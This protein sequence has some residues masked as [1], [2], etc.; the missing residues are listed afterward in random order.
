MTGAG[1]LRAREPDASGDCART[2]ATPR[3][4]P[5]ITSTGFRR[6]IVWPSM[7]RERTNFT[8]LP[9]FRPSTACAQGAGEDPQVEDSGHGTHGIRVGRSRLGLRPAADV[10]RFLRAAHLQ[11]AAGQ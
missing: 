2:V 8:T 3:S 7:V 6:R 5:T 4:T 11:G 1:S 10:S 9:R